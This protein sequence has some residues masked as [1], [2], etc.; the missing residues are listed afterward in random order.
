MSFDEQ[1]IG[2]GLLFKHYLVRPV[3]K[4]IAQPGPDQQLSVI[5]F[6]SAAARLKT[7]YFCIFRWSKY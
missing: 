1:K 3:Q 4:F 6:Q 2:T 5:H 7:L